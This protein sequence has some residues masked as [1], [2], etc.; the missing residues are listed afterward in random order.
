MAFRK[1]G[2]LEY[3]KKNNYVSSNITNNKNLNI[4]DHIGKLNTKIIVDSHLDLNNQSM[5]NVGNIYFSN[6]T[7]LQSL[8]DNSDLLKSNNIWLGD[9]TFTQI[10]NF[11]KIVAPSATIAAVTASYI[12][13]DTIDANILSCALGK[14]NTISAQQGY[15]NCVSD[16]NMNDTSIFGLNSIQG[17]GDIICNSDIDMNSRNISGL[18]S[19][20][21]AVQGSGDV[22]FKSN[23]D[24]NSR[25]ITGINIIQGTGDIICNSDIDMN[26]RNI[27]N[28]T[29]ISGSTTGVS[30]SNISSITGNTDILCNSDID[31]N[32]HFLK[33]L[34]SITLS[35]QTYSVQLSANSIGVITPTSTSVPSLG[36]GTTG[37]I[38]YGGISKSCYSSS[39]SSSTLTEE[40][41]YFGRNLLGNNEFNMVAISTYSGGM[42]S[43]PGATSITNTGFQEMLSIYASNGQ[44]SGNT[45][46]PGNVGPFVSLRQNFIDGITAQQ[47]GIIN[48]LATINGAVCCGEANYG[49]ESIT[50]SGLYFCRNLTG[51]YNEYDIVAI[52]NYNPSA[53]LNIYT[54]GTGITGHNSEVTGSIPLVSMNETEVNITGNMSANQVQCS[55]FSQ[56]DLLTFSVTQGNTAS[57]SYPNPTSITAISN[58][59]LISTQSFISPS[60]GGIV[61]LYCIIPEVT[62]NSTIAIGTSTNY[63][64][65][66][67]NN[68]ELVYCIYDNGSTTPYFLYE[69]GGLLEI[70]FSNDTTSNNKNYVY[71]KIT[72]SGGI[73]TNDYG[74]YTNNS[75]INFYCNIT[76]S[77]PITI[78]GIGG[79][80]GNPNSTGTTNQVITANGYGGWSWQDGGGGGSNLLPLNNL[81]TGVNNFNPPV[82]TY[83]STMPQGLTL[84]NNQNSSTPAGDNDIISYTPTSTQGLCIYSLSN[85]NS[86]VGQTP[87]IVLQPDGVKSSLVANGTNGVVQLT[88]LGG[89]SSNIILEA[90]TGVF[91]KDFPTI[92]FNNWGTLT[93]DSSGLNIL[94]TTINLATPTGGPTVNTILTPQANNLDISNPITLP[95]QTTYDSGATY[96]NVASTQEFVQKALASQGAGDVTSGGTNNFTGSNTF[97]FNL[98]GGTIT[99]PGLTL[100]RNVETGQNELD[101]VSINSTT[102]NGLS[103]Y[104]ETA[105]V[106]SASTPKIQVYNDGTATLFN[107]DITLPTQSQYNP[108]A[109][110]GNLAATQAFV[111]LAESGIFTATLSIPISSFVGSQSGF[112]TPTEAT[113]TQTYNS[114]T[115]T[116]TLYLTPFVFTAAS[117]SIQFTLTFPTVLYPDGSTPSFLAGSGLTYY[118]EDSYAYFIFVTTF[119]SSTQIR[120]STAPTASVGGSSQVSGQLLIGWT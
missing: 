6:G 14:F 61:T 107:T 39:L 47:N 55:S 91:L 83:G 63:I 26:S 57:V 88:A 24:M 7:D 17:P 113:F 23:I 28:M 92:N 20:Q 95:A 9:N 80:Q 81:W 53:I 31:M 36:I 43:I 50:E 22:L 84:T 10:T 115:Q 66:L 114:K 54:S 21:G 56:N 110:Y 48:N 77:V 11:Q 5:F 106:S 89:T 85:T 78:T 60:T 119:L 64:Q 32:N 37:N 12:N 100:A 104:C 72:Y 4:S 70:I 27:S 71:Y 117:S 108:G 45:G 116:N 93:A 8:E 35:E 69:E 40:G 98:N 13:T 49:Y 1:F 34:Q 73:I 75:T 3:N 65:F 33:N 86:C 111:Q 102:N 41:L 105:S 87:Q 2:G 82:Q 118:N 76:T 30:I 97:D 58:I 101:L 90:T 15:L 68:L 112:S 94:A 120:C 38:N 46:I 103:I 109:T 19:I 59:T 42:T 67:L 74:T 18:T 52:N 96:G 99:T 16:I 29:S 51:A 44:V 25:N 62:E 79:Y